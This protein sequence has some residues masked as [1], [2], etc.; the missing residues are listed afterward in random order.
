MPLCSAMADTAQLPRLTVS[1]YV[2]SLSDA[3]V[4]VFAA[5]SVRSALAVE[6]L[7]L[8]AAAPVKLG[9]TNVS[10]TLAGVAYDTS[11]AQR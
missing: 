1:V 2:P 4:S 8:L 10:V 5:F 9:A 11:S 3:A 7:P 6:G